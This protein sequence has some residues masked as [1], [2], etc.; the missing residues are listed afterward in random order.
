MNSW[1]VKHPPN[2]RVAPSGARNT[3]Y[4][5]GLLV[6][7]G[8]KIL[9]ALTIVLKGLFCESRWLLSGRRSRL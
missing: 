7:L 8:H 3:D 6:L 2:Y 5:H 9:T 4:Y 1:R